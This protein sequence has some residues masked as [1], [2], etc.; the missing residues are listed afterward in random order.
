MK[1][2]ANEGE[3]IDAKTPSVLVADDDLDDHE[4]LEAGVAP[5]EPTREE[6]DE[7][8]SPSRRQDGTVAD[9]RRRSST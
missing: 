9:S 8:L 6:V 4:A 5:L 7:A 3:I 1:D 2:T